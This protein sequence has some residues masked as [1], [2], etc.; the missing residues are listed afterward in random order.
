[1]QI[2][3]S[4]STRADKKYMVK[5]QNKTIHFGSSA[6]SDYTIHNDPE[7]KRRYIARHKAREKWTKS[8]IKTAGF[9]S[10]HLLWNKPT[11]SASIRDINNKFNVSIVKKN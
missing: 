8:G 9:W 3:L 5:I 1:M 7:R 10:K 4:K 2:I 6:H 11:L